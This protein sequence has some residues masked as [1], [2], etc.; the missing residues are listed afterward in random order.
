MKH[1]ICYFDLET[2]KLASEL[3]DDKKE[4]WRRLCAGEGGIS[5]LCIYDTLQEWPYFYDDYTVQDAAAHLESADIVVGFRSDK[6]DRLVVEGILRRKLA[7]KEHYDIF[8]MVK[9]ALGVRKMV[10][11]ENTLDAIC[12]RTLG[13]G[14]TGDGTHA[15]SLALENRWG[16]LFNYCC[17]DVKLARDLFEYIRTEGG[18]IGPGMQFLPV[19]LPEYLRREDGIRL[20]S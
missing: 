6:F 2:R 7:L 17:Q 9:D 4:G 15:P 11:G 8:E 12:K 20:N 19:I 1:R 18:V 3:S 10:R 14:K 16:Q 5:A 13:K